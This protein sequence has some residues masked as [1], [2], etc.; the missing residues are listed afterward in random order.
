MRNL[1][2][3]SITMRLGGCSS[4]SEISRRTMKIQSGRIQFINMFNS[5]RRPCTSIRAKINAGS[6]EFQVIGT[7]PPAFLYEDPDSYDPENALSGFMRGYFLG[8]VR[9]FGSHDISA[10][11]LSQCLRAIFTGPRTAMHVP[12]NRDRPSS[13]SVAELSTLRKITIPVMV[14]V[15]VLVGV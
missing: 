7:N 14:Y 15:A 12:S 13:R 4:P 11:L 9:C 10:N 3:V 6:E 5:L 1:I 8:H 2:A